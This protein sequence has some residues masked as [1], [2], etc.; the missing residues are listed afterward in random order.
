MKHLPEA[1]RN[2]ADGIRDSDAS[3]L[4]YW[5]LES[6]IKLIKDG[7]TVLNAIQSCH[8]HDSDEPSHFNPQG[9]DRYSVFLH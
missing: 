4:D 6:D 1:S 3:V 8:L 2:H 9:G 7:R 5:Y